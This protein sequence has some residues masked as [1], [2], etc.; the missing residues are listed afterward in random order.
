MA[1]SS[2][3]QL[4]GHVFVGLLG[5]AV[6][7]AFL[8]NNLSGLFQPPSAGPI[9][10]AEGRP[11]VHYQATPQSSVEQMLDMARVS[12]DDVVYD[13]GCGDG[14]FVITAALKYGARGVGIDIDPAMIEI[15]R[16]NAT[17]AGVEHLVE[18]R[19]EDLFDTDIREASVVA[20]FLLPDL[21]EMLVPK[22]KTLAAGSRILSYVFEI[23]GYPAD[24]KL[25]A[26][27]SIDGIQGNVMLRLW[28]TPLVEHAK[29]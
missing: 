26:P 20:L 22:L 16:R 28:E 15:S 1:R 5:G 10:R 9:P 14:R 23:P 19:Q 6:L 24:R 11:D 25:E 12:A 4:P 7:F 18:F 2:V 8:L 17:V 21:N 27:S 13:L 3:R 29:Y